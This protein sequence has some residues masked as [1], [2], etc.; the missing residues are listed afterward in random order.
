MLAVTITTVT[1]LTEP[2]TRAQGI[3]TMAPSSD[4]YAEITASSLAGDAHMDEEAAGPLCASSFSFLNR[5][6][7]RAGELMQARLAAWS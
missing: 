3:R 4:H 2:R 6:V 5:V 7:R 1:L